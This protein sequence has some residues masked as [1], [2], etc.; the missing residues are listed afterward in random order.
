MWRPGTPAL[1]FD[2]GKPKCC[3][4]GHRRQEARGEIFARRRPETP[5]GLRPPSV[6]GRRLPSHPDCRASLILIVAP[7]DGAFSRHSVQSTRR[8]TLR[9]S[10]ARDKPF[11]ATCGGAPGCRLAHLPRFRAICALNSA[12]RPRPGAS[13]APS[14]A[15]PASLRRQQPPVPAPPGNCQPSAELPREGT[16]RPAPP[17]RPRPPAFPAPDPP[18]PSRQTP[19][20]ESIRGPQVSV[21]ALQRPN[22]WGPRATC[23]QQ[24]RT[25]R[26]G[27]RAIPRKAAKL[28]RARLASG[29]T[30]RRARLAYLRRERSG[31]PWARVARRVGYASDRAARGMARRYAKRAGRPWPV[32]LG[33]APSANLVRETH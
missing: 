14:C 17:P 23:T 9:G 5:V 28:Y 20:A 27:P 4:T 1:S 11:Q 29:D 26:A 2:S 21:T 24:R 15:L 10:S 25:S 31:K 12:G 32:P 8:P 3:P 18:T 30:L 7:Q 19:G 13:A 22:Q 6:P 16:R 33:A